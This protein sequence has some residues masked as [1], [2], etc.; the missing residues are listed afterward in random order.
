MRKIVTG[1]L[2]V[3][4][5]ASAAYTGFCA[6]V[7]Y[8]TPARPVASYDFAPECE[9]ITHTSNTHRG[10]QLECQNRISEAQRLRQHPGLAVRD[11]DNLTIFFDG[12]PISRLVPVEVDQDDTTCNS[13]EI[14]DVV[15]AAETANGRRRDLA[16]VSCYQ[17]EFESRFVVMPDGSRWPTYGA[18]AAPNG[19]AVADGDNRWD[20]EG[21]QGRLTLYGWPSRKIVA[22]FR[23]SCRALAWQDDRHFTATCVLDPD[24]G[25]VSQTPAF[26]LAFAPQVGFDAKVWQD[27]KGIWQMQATRW[28]RGRLH[29]DDAGNM[30]YPPAF[31]LRP[32][33]HFTAAS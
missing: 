5:L 8:G 2:L 33:P 6:W 26:I 14:N 13:Y 27:D 9:K 18:K 30:E 20:P 29:F 15:T 32:L 11:G 16:L 10:S 22:R 24:S 1:L 25:P 21:G 23:P 28:L 7:A 4:L 12:A 19:R 17:G 3:S 31:S